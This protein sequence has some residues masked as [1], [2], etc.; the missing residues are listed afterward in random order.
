[1]SDLRPARVALSDLGRLGVFGLQTRPLRTLLS[2]LGIAVGIAA[3]IAVVGIADSSQASVNRQLAALGT[4][5][6]R[7]APGQTVFGEAAHLPVESVAMVRRIG[8]VTSASATGHLSGANVYRSDRI[9]SA[10]TGSIAVL[11]ARVDLLATLD[12]HLL[13]GAWLNAA[14]A[15]FPAVVLGHDAA[16][17]LGVVRPGLSTQVWLDSHWFTVVGILAAVPLAPEIDSSALIGWPVAQSLLGFD[18]YPTTIYARSRDD[19]VLAVKAALGATAD[20]EHPEQVNVSRPSDALAARAAI[21]STLQTL[22]IG[23]GA[24]ALFVG[25]VGVANTMIISVMERRT[26]I[27]L[28]RALGATRGNVRAQFLAESM[29]LALLGGFAGVALGI[30]ILA[31]FAYHESWPAL[32]PAW[33]SAG[34]IAVTLVVGAGAGFYPA[35]R[36]ARLPPTQT[37]GG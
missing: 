34:A 2:A 25:A 9:P 14:T 20:P 21:D 12:A 3:M 22:L 23:L 8:P 15:R 13:D 36:A 1:M 5:L 31:G 33:V 24:V 10:E 37:L 16:T 4:N 35:L 30:V 29:L 7:V 28:R 26:E 17:R 6:L 18:G 11:A 19:A 32:L 27:G